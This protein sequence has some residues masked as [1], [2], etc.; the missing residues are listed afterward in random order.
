MAPPRGSSFPSWQGSR[1]IADPYPSP[2]P[3]PGNEPRCRS[4]IRRIAR[5]SLREAGLLGPHWLLLLPA[6]AFARGI[7]RR[8]WRACWIAALVGTFLWGALV[9]YGRVLTPTRVPA[10]ALAG[11][12][13]AALMGTDKPCLRGLFRTLILLVL[14]WN[15]TVIATDLNLDRARIV[16]GH[17]RDA[18]HLQR[19]VSYGAVLPFVSEALPDD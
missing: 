17:S 11:A 16:S 18:E 2:G 4:R 1:R 9:Q 12:A 8:V 5:I 6:A 13:A 15:A 19:W 7:D 3:S 10:A 14:S